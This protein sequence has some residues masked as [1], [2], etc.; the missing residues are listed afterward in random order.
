MGI[1]VGGLLAGILDIT[2]A[3]LITLWYGGSPVRMLQGIASGVLGKAAFDG[4]TPTALL[5]LAFHFLIAFT[6]TTVFYLASRKIAFLT[7]KPVV[8][9][10]LFGVAVYL[11][12]YFV[13]QPLA[14]IH[15]KFTLVSV[16]RAV[17]VHVFCV[18]LPISLSVRRYGSGR[19]DHDPA[20]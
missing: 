13:V 8:A 16:P 17:L 5:G 11:F 19:R 14:G 6:A 2:S 7:A 15:P 10:I 1:L 20:H 9:G 3:I 4:G 12:M 18:G